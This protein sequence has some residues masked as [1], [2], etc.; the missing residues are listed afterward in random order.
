MEITERKIPV[1]RLESIVRSSSRSKDE[2]WLTRLQS[3][4]V[5]RR[6]RGRPV[7]ELLQDKDPKLNVDV[8]GLLVEDRERR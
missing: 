2:A 8:V 4:G 3:E 7:K 6:G 5:I 1:A